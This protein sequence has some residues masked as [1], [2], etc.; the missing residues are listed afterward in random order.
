MCRKRPLLHVLSRVWPEN[1]K[2]WSD[3]P[4]QLLH[5]LRVVR[6]EELHHETKDGVFRSW[7]RDI[8]GHGRGKVTLQPLLCLIWFVKNIWKSHFVFNRTTESQLTSDLFQRWLQQIQPHLQETEHYVTESVLVPET[9]CFTFVSVSS[10]LTWTKPELIA[11]ATCRHSLW[12]LRHPAALWEIGGKSESRPT[13]AQT[14]KTVDGGVF[15]FHVTCPN[16]R[17]QTAA[18]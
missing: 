2:V 17:V 15:P 18:M 3:L 14:H 12:H 7:R 16:L 1:R 6:R 8:T 5:E 4:S 13:M 10:L 11:S 9:C